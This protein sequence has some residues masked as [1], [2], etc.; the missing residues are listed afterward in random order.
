[1]KRF[2]ACAF[3][4][5][6]SFL[7]AMNQQEKPRPVLGAPVPDESKLQP[8]R[9]CCIPAEQSFI[10]YKYDHQWR[11]AIVYTMYE[12]NNF[13]NP[14]MIIWIR[15]DENAKK[16]VAEFKDLRSDS[17]VRYEGGSL[18]LFG[19]KNVQTFELKK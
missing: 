10:A 5:S 17:N 13:Q 7:I 1:M 16:I 12:R 15:K 14:R 19:A 4:L 18:E 2:I 11:Y 9:N 6:A 3:L 8:L